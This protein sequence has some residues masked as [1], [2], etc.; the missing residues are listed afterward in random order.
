MGLRPPTK[1]RHLLLRGLRR[2][3]PVLD[4]WRPCREPWRRRRSAAGEFSRHGVQRPSTPIRRE[5]EHAMSAAVAQ[6]RAWGV[7]PLIEKNRARFRAAAA[8]PARSR[9][10]G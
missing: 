8:T 3:V 6:A 2:V 10:A 4:A 9:T 7:N 1:L 5:A